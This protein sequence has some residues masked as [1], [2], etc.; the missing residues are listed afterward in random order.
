M[1]RTGGKS[2]E[3]EAKVPQGHC[4]HMVHQLLGADFV[5][6]REPQAAGLSCGRW[7]PCA[8]HG[9]AG[10]GGEDFAVIQSLGRFQ[11]ITEEFIDIGINVGTGKGFTHLPSEF[12]D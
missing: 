1:I 4:L 8:R 2:N 10:E 5:S 11:F 6:S 9:E 3:T 12:L 7:S